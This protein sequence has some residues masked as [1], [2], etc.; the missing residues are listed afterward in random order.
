MCLS[1]RPEKFVGERETWDNAEFA[2]LAA[3]QAQNQSWTINE[4][5]GAFYGPKI[6]FSVV[7]ALGRRPCPSAC[8]NHSHCALYPL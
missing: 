6:D 7:D 2:L 1:T 5:D 8:Q 3:L 4:G